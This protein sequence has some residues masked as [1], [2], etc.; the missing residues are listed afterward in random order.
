MSTTDDARAAE[1]SSPLAGQWRAAE[2]AEGKQQ[3]LQAIDEAT[4]SMGRFRRGKA[5]GR[6]AEHTSPPETL[7]IEVEGSKVRIGSG[8]RGLE[9]ELGGP[10]IEV[11]GRQG[12][13]RLSAR[14]EGERLIV[15]ARSD[16]GG[17][18]TTYRADEDRLVME[19]TMTGDKLA[20]PLKYVT[21]YLRVE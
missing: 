10:P 21:T 6:L 9:L 18:T 11:E 14:M 8:D 2:T 3:R 4:E 1:A 15:E 20:G 7:T 17:R 13:A 16:G 12:K 19:V 5:R